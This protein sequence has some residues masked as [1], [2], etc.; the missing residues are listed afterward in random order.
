VSASNA[1]QPVHAMSHIRRRLS[2]APD[3]RPWHALADGG[4]M[5]S[6]RGQERIQTGD[7]VVTGP[8]HADGAPAPFGTL[9]VRP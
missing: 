2:G 8:H 3:H 6:V 7:A 5:C 4:V 9:H 1:S